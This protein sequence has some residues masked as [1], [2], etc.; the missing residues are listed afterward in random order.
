MKPHFVPVL[1]QFSLEGGC[2]GEQSDSDLGPRDCYMQHICQPAPGY[3]KYVR[4]DWWPKEGGKEAKKR[5]RT[6]V[7]GRDVV[8]RL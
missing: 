7:G 8:G 6:G 4:G 3:G 5:R 1:L 2:H